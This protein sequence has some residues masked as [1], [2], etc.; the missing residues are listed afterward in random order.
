MSLI[1]T[2]HPLELTKHDMLNRSL[3]RHFWLW[4]L[5]F[6]CSAVFHS[7]WT[8]GLQHAGLPYPSPSPRVCSSS[9]PL[10]QWCYLTISSSVIPFSC[11]QSCPASGSFL[12]QLFTSGGQ[13]IGASASVSILPMNIQDW[14]PL[15]LTGL[16]SLQS[17]GLPRVFFN[18]TVQKHQIFNAQ[19]KSAAAAKSLQSCPTL[20]GRIDSSPPG[21][22]V[23][24]ILQARTL[25]WVAI[26]FSNAWKWKWSRW[27]LFVVW[28]L[29]LAT[30]LT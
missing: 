19:L 6:S 13:N 26:S 15:W 14:F 16:I 25:E 17:K 2:K 20:C 9:Y 4:L 12:S 5:L 21:S 23:P 18:T 29:R 7:L 11:L 10:S 28:P 1:A 27:S 30:H 22:P 8:H 24:G 3:I